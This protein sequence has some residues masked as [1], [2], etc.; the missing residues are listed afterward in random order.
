MATTPTPNP[1]PASS[2]CY[3]CGKEQSARITELLDLIWERNLT[4]EEH[5]ELDADTAAN[6]PTCFN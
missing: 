5:A 2:R 3:D 6:H 4:D 1:E